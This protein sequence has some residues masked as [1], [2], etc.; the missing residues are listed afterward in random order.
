VYNVS[1]AI[2]VQTLA[3]ALK[4]G[5]IA[6]VNIGGMQWLVGCCACRQGGTTPNAVEFSNVGSCSASSTAALRP[7]I[8][9]ANW[10]GFGNT[11]GAATQTMTLTF[12]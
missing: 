7:W 1:D 12:S 4:N 8:G 3:T 5:D 6:S 11:V 10:G 2:K 9:N